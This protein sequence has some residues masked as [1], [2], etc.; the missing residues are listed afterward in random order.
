MKKIIP[1]LIRLHVIVY[2]QLRSKKIIKA[3]L[4][5]M[6]LMGIVFSVDAQ[7][8]IYGKVISVDD[9]PLANANVLLLNTKDSSLAKGQLTNSTGVYSFEN[10]PQGQYFISYSY[11][12]YKNE[13]S[14][15]VTIS[16]KQ[17]SLNLG[18]IKLTESHLQLKE[19]T[20]EAK[21]PL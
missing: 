5:F 12:S 3:L 9:K 6:L 11:T 4:L 20:I 14:D 10:I 16:D 19:V 17:Q 8:K 18:I 7:T 15:A 13:Y 1:G 21:K 2:L